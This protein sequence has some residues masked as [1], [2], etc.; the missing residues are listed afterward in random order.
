M[1]SFSAGVTVS[2]SFHYT[3]EAERADIM[4]LVGSLLV[5]CPATRIEYDGQA[6]HHGAGHDIFVKVPIHGL[7][8][9]LCGGRYE[10]LPEKIHALKRDLLA[11]QLLEDFPVIMGT[12]KHPSSTSGE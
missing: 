5:M 7:A 4:D 3:E 2:A 10:D 11:R 8:S 1:I 6:L 12:I 9:S